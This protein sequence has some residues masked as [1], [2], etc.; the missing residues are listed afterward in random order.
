M[1][2]CVIARAGKDFV[3]RLYE[4]LCSKP[5]SVHIQVLTRVLT[6][7]IHDKFKDTAL[8]SRV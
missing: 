5:A 7:H 6:V 2:A 1:S 4:V 8:A 3:L